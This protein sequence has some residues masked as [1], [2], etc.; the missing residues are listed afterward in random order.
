MAVKQF[1]HDIDLVSVGQLLNA[2]VHNVDNAAETVL[3]GALTAAEA[4]FQVYN[5]D[6]NALKVWDG[7]QFNQ[8]AAAIAGDVI[9]YGVV[10]DLTSAGNPAT[11]VAGAQYV[12]GAAGTL[13]WTGITFSPSADVQI[14]DVILYTGATTATVI[15]RNDAIATETV[16]GNV[17]LATQAEVITGTVTDEA[18]TPATLAGWASNF[19]FAKT[20]SATVNLPNNTAFTVNHALALTT[21][22]AFVVNVMDPAGSQIS[23]DV[24]SVDANNLTLTARPAV[25]GAVVT[26]VGY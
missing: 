15:Q 3:A 10:T 8:V 18:V 13:A 17:L 1:Y 14:G 24:D 2:R 16:A 12:A 4:G 26:V 11:E 9:F 19:Q 6:V 23:V 21:K 22:D 25:T 7:T 5:T 20:Y